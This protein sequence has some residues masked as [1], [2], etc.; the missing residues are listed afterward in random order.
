MQPF[1]SDRNRDTRSTQSAHVSGSSATG[2]QTSIARD[3]FSN[4]VIHLSSRSLLVVFLALVGLILG[5]SSFYNPDSG[6]SLIFFIVTY[7]CVLF[8]FVWT[9]RT[10]TDSFNLLNLFLLAGF[11]RLHLPALIG[12]PFD[13]DIRLFS[14]LSITYSDWTR[15]NIMGLIGTLSVILGWMIGPHL[16]ISIIRT[17]LSLLSIGKDSKHLVL[18]S[19]LGTVI[20]LIG[21]LSFIQMNGLSI[22]SAAQSGEFRNTEIQEGTGFLFWIGLIGI[23]CSSILATAH[24]QNKKPIIIAAIPVLFV[25]A[26]FWILGGRFRAMTPLISLS[27]IIIYNHKISARNFRVFLAIMAIISII[28]PYLLY[29]GFL[30]RNGLGISAFP[31]AAN[32]SQLTNYAG[33]SVAREIG[34]TFS[35]A[36][37]ARLEPGV[38]HGQTFNAFLWPISDFIGIDG[39]SSGKYIIETLV[40]TDSFGIHPTIIGDTYLNYGLIAVPIILILFGAICRALYLAFKLEYV[41][42]PLY[43][44]SA[45][46]LLRIYYESVDKYKE[47]LVILL[48]MILFYK[49]GQYFGLSQRA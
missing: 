46:Y 31:A 37:V 33:R 34:Q 5:F 6:L 18:I 2:S 19:T 21:V 16:F 3:R 48:F 26:S 17:I 30:Y 20:G 41:P 36:A 29:A 35:L 8:T 9:Y 10:Y 40:G 42:L 15:G 38:L 45:I 14:Q 25:V 49:L 12:D 23:G 13:P 28:V 47:F 11:L 43:T 22:L 27:L 24:L 1:F 7:F 44:I 4:E 32:I 39:K